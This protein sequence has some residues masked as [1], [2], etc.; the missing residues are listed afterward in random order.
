M[1]YLP[2]RE[3]SPKRLS[4]VYSSSH[5]LTQTQISIFTFYQHNLVRS[6]EKTRPCF[7]I[8]ST[9]YLWG[10]NM[11]C[12]VISFCGNEFHF[13]ESHQINWW[14]VNLKYNVLYVPRSCFNTLAFHK[15]HNIKFKDATKYKVSGY[16]DEFEF[17]CHF[18]VV[19]LC[20]SAMICKCIHP[21]YEICWKF[22]IL[23]FEIE[24]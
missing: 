17:K 6:R 20:T 9:P 11:S 21:E 22:W 18:V 16:C 13:Y 1:P 23:N 4:S 5:L 19:S 10:V 2:A 24:F 14:G 15:F 3:I 7:N 8:F 12:Q